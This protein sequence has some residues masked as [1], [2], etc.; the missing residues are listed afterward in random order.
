MKNE[1][2]Q[3]EKEDKIVER[4]SFTQPSTSTY[5]T[6]Q[7][8][9]QQK[10]SSSSWVDCWV[11]DSVHT[12]AQFRLLNSYVKGPALRVRHIITKDHV[13]ILRLLHAL[14]FPL[15]DLCLFP[16]LLITGLLQLLF[17]NF[18]Y[19]GGLQS[20]GMYMP[21]TFV[22]WHVIQSGFRSA[23]GQVTP[24][25]YFRQGPV[26]FCAEWVRFSLLL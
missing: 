4:W 10:V 16:P 6:R 3:R 1:K 26:S 13:I 14:R 2:R 17:L 18:Q 9:R 20:R 23:R 24:I 8:Q 22:L 19:L 15:K 25:L 11:S 5:I 21:F 12:W 7:T